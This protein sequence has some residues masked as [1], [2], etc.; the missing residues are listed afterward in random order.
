[1]DSYV[2]SC[3]NVH[4]LIHIASH[5]PYLYYNDPDVFYPSQA[6]VDVMVQVH[7]FHRHFNKKRDLLASCHQYPLAT[8]LYAHMFKS[9]VLGLLEK[10]GVFTCCPLTVE[11]DTVHVIHE[12]TVHIPSCRASNVVVVD[13]IMPNQTRNQLHIASK[14]GKGGGGEAIVDYFDAWIPGIGAFSSGH[15]KQSSCG[16]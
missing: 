9:F 14:Q 3:D 1:V 6:V 4:S 15:W 16:I 12:R 13:Q 10:G 2:S 11:Q 7:A 8:V 5:P